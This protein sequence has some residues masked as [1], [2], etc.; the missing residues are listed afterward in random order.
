MLGELWSKITAFDKDAQLVIVS[1]TAFLGVR[2]SKLS[3]PRAKSLEHAGELQGLDVRQQIGH[4]ALPTVMDSGLT[5]P[6]AAH[7]LMT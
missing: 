4:L 2:A 5:I 6:R 3:S 1:V 7:G